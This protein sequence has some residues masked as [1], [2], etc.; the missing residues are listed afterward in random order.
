MTTSS[1]ARKS[2]Y[3]RPLSELEV[4]KLVTRLSR[5]RVAPWHLDALQS[6]LSGA[7]AEVGEV[8]RPRVKFCWAGH[9]VTP[10]NSIMYINAKGQLRRKSCRPCKQFREHIKDLHAASF[11]LE[12]F[13]VPEGDDL[14]PD[15]ELDELIGF[16]L[17]DTPDRPEVQ[18]W[19]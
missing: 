8:G 10:E 13:A 17:I 2:E 7:I 15:I 14:I 19:L 9:E 16:S 11:S 1:T 18:P 5:V 4:S 3:R 6:A 12:R